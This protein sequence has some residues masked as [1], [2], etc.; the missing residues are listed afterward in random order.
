ML[1]RGMLGLGRLHSIPGHLLRKY[2]GAFLE[3]PWPEL[4]LDLDVKCVRPATQLRTQAKNI[5]REHDW[6]RPV[7]GGQMR[8]AYCLNTRSFK[9]LRKAFRCEPGEF[10]LP[11]FGLRQSMA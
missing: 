9:G 11:E 5:Q 8:I 6:H 2:P 3:T 4:Y 10:D 1:I 7:G